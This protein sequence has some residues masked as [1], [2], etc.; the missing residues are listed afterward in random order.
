MISGRSE[1]VWQRKVSPRVTRV[2]VI[3][4]EK[5]QTGVAS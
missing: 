2:I 3:S 1:D 4:E 5:I